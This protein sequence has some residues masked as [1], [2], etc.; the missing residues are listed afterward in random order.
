VIEDIPLVVDAA[1]KGPK[2]T[3]PVGRSN[4]ISRVTVNVEEAR[5]TIRH[6][7]GEELLFKVTWKIYDRNGKFGSISILNSFSLQPSAK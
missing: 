1:R 5:E 4:Y 6:Q 7:R 2:H 3:T